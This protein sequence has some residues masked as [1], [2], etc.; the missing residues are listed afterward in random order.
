LHHGAHEPPLLEIPLKSQVIAIDEIVE[1][2]PS[3]PTNKEVL[4][5]SNDCGDGYITDVDTLILDPSSDDTSG[6]KAH[7]KIKRE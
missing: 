3:R 6:V 7:D 2:I 4:Y 5:A 1:H